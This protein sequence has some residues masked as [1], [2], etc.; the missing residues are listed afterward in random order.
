[1]EGGPEV[2]KC[3][4]RVGSRRGRR[5]GPEEPRAGPWAGRRQLLYLFF[6]PGWP[7]GGAGSVAQLQS[8]CW[9]IRWHWGC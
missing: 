2:R 1:M 9:V 4:V 7:W 8:G 5:C 6:L 3:L